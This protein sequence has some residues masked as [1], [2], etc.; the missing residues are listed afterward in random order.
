M[1]TP[2]QVTAHLLAQ[3]LINKT[4]Q[5]KDLE[6]EVDLLRLEIFDAAEGGIQCT[7]GKVFFVESNTVLQ[8]DRERLKEELIARFELTEESAAS[9]IDSCK[10]PRERSPYIMVHLD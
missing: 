2:N 5:I 10:V 1:Q 8:L 3:E 6:S 9:L 4:R 7:G